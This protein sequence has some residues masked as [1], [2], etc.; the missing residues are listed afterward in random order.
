MSRLA[1]PRSLPQPYLIIGPLEVAPWATLAF[2]AAVWPAANRAIYFPL[3]LPVTV[4]LKSV[5]IWVSVATAGTFDLGLY[6][7]DGTTR[8][9]SMGSTTMV[10][11]SINTW[12]LATPILVEAGVRYYLGMSCSTASTA[13]IL[14]QNLIITAM[15]GIGASQQ[16]T[17]HPLPSPAVPAQTTTAY[18]PMFA[19]T[20]V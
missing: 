16:A 11:A 2:S 7:G 10:A 14:R 20:F 15:R 13:T 3:R 19:L 6:A 5:S 4:L 8:L 9:D 17:A 1:S 18:A 12:T